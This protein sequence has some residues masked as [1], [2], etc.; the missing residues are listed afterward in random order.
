MSCFEQ[1]HD[2]LSTLN[3]LQLI[4]KICKRVQRG[5][6]LDFLC[7]AKTPWHALGI[8]A[9]LAS[10]SGES[11][12]V[13]IVPHSIDGY[14][15]SPSSFESTQYHDIDF[16]RFTGT[17]DSDLNIMDYSRIVYSSVLGYVIP[18]FL[19]NDE[20]KVIV[21][22][23]RHQTLARA[24]TY[25]S[26]CSLGRPKYVSVD[27]GLGRYFDFEEDDE[28]E[29]GTET[30]PSVRDFYYRTLQM[31]EQAYFKRVPQQDNAL[32]SVVDG[33]LVANEDI[34]QR[35]QAV[36][37]STEDKDGNIEGLLLTQPFVE[38]DRISDSDMTDLVYEM[39][40]LFTSDQTV[41]LKPHP[42]ENVGRYERIDERELKILDKET[43]LEKIFPEYDPETVVGFTST[44]LLTAHL[45]YNA[46]S[47]S[48]IDL[49]RKYA[50][51]SHLL[52]V[53]SQFE[54][55]ASHYVSFQQ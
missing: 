45:F 40:S 5:M 21:P 34:I 15:L 19:G 48:V 7:R 28:S 20:I 49:L 6:E 35:Y 10:S 52:K 23:D 16:Y 8:D 11:G 33:K 43:P 36:L 51:D 31:T 14:L 32:F 3:S 54:Q 44:A 13:L 22:D 26:V 46:E 17:P 29:D 50:T 1:N 41:A 30:G 53:C 27:E 47:V 42:R 24:F 2:R 9:E 38:R 55:L 39:I 18:L 25:P 37:P 4:D 12:I